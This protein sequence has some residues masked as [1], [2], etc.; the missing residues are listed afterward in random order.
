MALHI[1]RVHQRDGWRQR[2][3]PWLA[4]YA[5]AMR[6]V[7]LEQ[8]I[9]TNPDDPAGYLVYADWLQAN[10]DPRGELIVLFE[11]GTPEER[12][13]F[14]A[15]HAEAFLGPFAQRKPRTLE[16]DWRHGFV[17]GATIGWKTF[18][19]DREQCEQDFDAFLA[20]DS[21]RFIEKLHLGPVPGQD[22]M[23][24]GGLAEVIDNRKPATL[25]ELYLGSVG[26]W[27]IS[28]TYTAMPDCAAIRG[29]R[30][31][32]LRA[33]SISIG[34]IDLPELRSFTVETGSL[35]RPELE[36]IAH[37]KWPNLESLTIWFG[38]PNYGADGSIEDIRRILD[39]V[40]LAK[41]THL[42]LMNCE[43]VDE[44]AA[45]LPSSKIL[46]QLASLD[47][48]MG[49]LSDEGLAAMLAAKDRFAHLQQ[50]NLEDNAL[51]NA[52]WPAVRELAKN[53]VFGTDHDPD[54]AESRY[55]SVGE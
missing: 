51:T 17:R 55:V 8:V 23:G 15:S 44:I 49:C 47:L 29:L 37:A 36:K 52:H 43:F 27:D 21:C 32:T 41:L 45:A 24:L 30:T 12:E 6:N 28:S 11:R 39:G 1:T 18:G 19:K 53:V 40:G 4:R 5:R 33:G 38:D 7:E 22:E 20:L 2:L 35:T 3:S 34:D 26:D 14:L 48:S 46:P 10:G 54:R 50:L 9:L 13:A 16:L 25:R 31:L 42:G